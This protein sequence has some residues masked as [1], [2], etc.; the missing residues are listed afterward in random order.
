MTRRRMALALPV[1]LLAQLGLVAVGVWPQLS[2]RAVG[3]EIQLRVRPV[4]PIDPFRGAYVAL[5]YPDL[6]AD[7]ARRVGGGLGAMED[8][9]SGPVFITLREDGGVWVAEDWSRSRPDDAT[10]LRCSDRGWQIRCGIESW[11]LPQQD[12]LALE[13]AVSRGTVVA[14]VSVDGRGNAA[15]VG[16]TQEPA[17][18]AQGS[19]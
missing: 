2:A 19:R 12:A 1:L 10:Y 4:D 9:A 6:R 3:D 14:T 8:G 5:S 7:G 13:R 16:V 17:P 18:P 15:I 11:F